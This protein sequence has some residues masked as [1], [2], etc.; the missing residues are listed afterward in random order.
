MIGLV[1]LS[2]SHIALKCGE[3]DASARQVVLRSVFK[4][5]FF[6]FITFKINKVL[7]ISFRS[8]HCFVFSSSPKSPAEKG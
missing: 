8:N 5:C 4:T 6:S 1:Y 3:I 2:K 7:N